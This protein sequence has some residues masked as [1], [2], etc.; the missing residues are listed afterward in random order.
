MHTSGFIALFTTTLAASAGFAATSCSAEND[1]TPAN[2]ELPSETTSIGSSGGSLI[3]A[4]GTRLDIPQ[5][6][7]ADT[8]KIEMRQIAAPE[9]A[10]GP[11]Y[12]LQ[13]EG[14]TF[15]VPVTITLPFA[16]EQ[17]DAEQAP[18]IFTAPAGHT[19][20]E[21]LETEASDA[22][23]AR[24][25][26]S[27][28]SVFFSGKIAAAPVALATGENFPGGIASSGSHV[29]W[30]N[31]GSI[32]NPVQGGEGLLMRAKSTGG[33]AM[34]VSPAQK[35][36]KWLALNTTSVF[37]TNGGTA[38]QGAG[39]W[40]APIE[41][42]DPSLVAGGA[43][44]SGV[45]ASDEVTVFADIDTGTIL[46]V[47]AG[48]GTAT[49]LATANK[50]RG[51]A[52]SGGTVY[53]TSAGAVSSVPLAGG[54]ATVLASG[55]SDPRGITAK[56][57]YVYW[58][59]YGSGEVKRISASSGAQQTIASGQSRP[60]A[61][62][63]DSTH[64]YWTNLGAGSVVRAPLAGGAESILAREQAAPYA[65]ALDAKNVYWTNNGNGINQGAVMMRVK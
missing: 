8:V 39:L 20:F 3:L 30:V 23:H 48:G 28:F 31:Q 56:G 47:P 65:I 22:T 2:V 26:T 11:A 44:P 34:V 51:V 15:A 4:D 52:I 64:A 5:G 57:G 16:P 7:L 35:D 18:I 58:T 50:P 38:G 43:F 36:P 37:W 61:I 41:G 14:Q 13:P 17:L 45:A 53:F 27:H 60:V 24:A 10:V 49:V 33:G 6:A 12:L 21:A 1:P 54:A 63:V 55:L 42:G 46:A 29:Y 40:Q 32:A 9:N 25:K 19:T 59:D 62:E